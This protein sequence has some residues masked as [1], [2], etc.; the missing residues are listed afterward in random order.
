MLEG[1]GEA[2]TLVAQ[3]QPRML[4]DV[5]AAVG[6]GHHAVAAG[7]VMVSHAL[8]RAVVLRDVEVDGPGPQHVGH[9]HQRRVKRR[10]VLP[11][12]AIGKQ[13]RLGRVIAH[14]VEQRMR[15]VGLEADDA[16]AVGLLQRVHHGLPA[17][18]AAP[19]DLAFGGKAL[20]IVLGDIAGLAPGLRDQL[21]VCGGVLG[22]IAGA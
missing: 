13:R 7:L 10:L 12:E 6:I 4:G 17:V 18:H 5:E 19:A 15:H 21:G 14:G 8:H 11:V 9:L 2:A 22:P 20:A 1:L 3:P 16:G